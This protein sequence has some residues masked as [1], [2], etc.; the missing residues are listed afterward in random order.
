MKRT[1]IAVLLLLVFGVG[2][3]EGQDRHSPQDRQLSNG[4]KLFGARTLNNGT[5]TMERVEFPNGIR[6]FDVTTLPD[7][8]QTVRR[9]ELPDGQK[10]FNVT[11]SFQK[12][13]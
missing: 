4:T 1:I 12:A 5:E 3:A 13:P 2:F 11:L 7:R 6:Q 9:V 8:T 10:T